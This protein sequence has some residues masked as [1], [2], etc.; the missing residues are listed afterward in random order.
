MGT[1]I[2]EDLNLNYPGDWGSKFLCNV[3]KCLPV[4]TVY[5]AEVFNVPYIH[6]NFQNTSSS[7]WYFSEF[8]LLE[9]DDVSLPQCFSV[10]WRNVVP[11]EPLKE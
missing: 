8:S 4:N 11:S 1:N 10:F 9:C 3:S 2:L 5:I 7:H 6:M